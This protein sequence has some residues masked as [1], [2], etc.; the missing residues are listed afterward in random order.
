MKHDVRHAMKSAPA[1]FRMVL[2]H[3]VIEARLLH[4]ADDDL[5][6]KLLTGDNNGHAPELMSEALTLGAASVDAEVR[7]LEG[8]LM[9]AD[10]IV[11]EAFEGNGKTAKRTPLRTGILH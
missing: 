11:A 5:R 3:R 2:E 10:A 8:L 6:A 1:L 7:R 4:K 9:T